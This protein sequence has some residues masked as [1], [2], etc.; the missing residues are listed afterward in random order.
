M[1]KDA[2]LATL[3]GLVLGLTIAGAFIF[4]PALIKALPKL[5]LPTITLPKTPTKT[6]PIPSPSSKEFGITITAPLPDAV[7]PKSDIVVSGTTGAGAVVVIQGPLDE[8]VGLADVNGAYA[9]QVT[10]TEGKND[11]TA[12]AYGTEGKQA[13]STVTIYFTQESF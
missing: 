10:A 7:E 11:I 2:I 6:T 8:D 13:Q 1:N 12:T 3:I 5:T 9:G 4:G